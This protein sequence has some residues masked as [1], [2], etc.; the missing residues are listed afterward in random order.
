MQ[1]EEKMPGTGKEMQ[2]TGKELFDHLEQIHTTEMGQERIKRNLSLQTNDVVAWCVEKISDPCA[3]I[4]RKG[5]NWYVSVEGCIFTINAYSYTII[6][7]HK[8]GSL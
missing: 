5:K 2:E 8:N 6:T 4:M 3:V 7:A 1:S